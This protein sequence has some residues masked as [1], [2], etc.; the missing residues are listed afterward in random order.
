MRSTFLAI[1][2]ISTTTLGGCSE[3]VLNP[4]GPIASAERQILFNS[5]GIMLA[6]VIPTILV[7]LGVAYWFRSSNHRARY[8][9]N[10]AYS[11]RLELLVWSIPT[12]TV[13]LVGGVAW[14]GSHEV[15]PRQPIV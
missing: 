10:F 7:T 8:R 14:V 12:M 2:F 15:S 5:L 11:G 6:I 1:F 4:Q 3:G 9:P 13:L